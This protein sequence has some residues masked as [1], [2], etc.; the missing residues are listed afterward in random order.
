[1]RVGEAKD[2]SQAGY[3]LSLIFNQ[4]G[5]EKNDFLCQVISYEYPTYSWEK[6]RFCLKGEYKEMINEILTE[7]DDEENTERGE[8]VKGNNY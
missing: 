4:L 1:M 2:E 6:D 5:Q 7:L 8:P 3:F